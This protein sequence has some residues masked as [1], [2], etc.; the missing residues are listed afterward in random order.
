[1]CPEDRG[2]LGALL[3]PLLLCPTP[4]SHGAPP[5]HC[6]S[7]HVFNCVPLR[8]AADVVT[9]VCLISP[10][11]GTL[12][13]AGSGLLLIWPEAAHF[14]FP[15]RSVLTICPVCLASGSCAVLYCA[16]SSH[17]TPVAGPPQA[18]PSTMHCLCSRSP[19]AQNAFPPQCG[20]AISYSS[21]EAQ[22][23]CHLSCDAFPCCSGLAPN[24]AV[25]P[26]N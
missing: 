9:W 26:W 10:D 13:T 15:D 25:P 17:T 23:K 22:V 7:T 4:H 2:P 12:C 6:L 24:A 16:H 3:G 21:F 14:C 11:A 5:F 1:M 19:P 8:T 20:L 18:G